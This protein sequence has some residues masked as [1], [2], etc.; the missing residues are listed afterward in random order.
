MT[1][2]QIGEELTAD[3]PIYAGYTYIAQLETLEYKLII[4]DIF[5]TAEDLIRD[6]KSQQIP[7]LR[8]Y[9]YNMFA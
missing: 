3:Y 4:S 8:I 5:G 1:E 7:V 2:K 6:L 9:K